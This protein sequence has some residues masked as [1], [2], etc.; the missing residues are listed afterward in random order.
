M[1]RCTEAQGRMI[2]NNFKQDIENIKYKIAKNFSDMDLENNYA[3]EDMKEIIEQMKL[4][5]SRLEERIINK[6]NRLKG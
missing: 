4:E 5:C 1:G 3:H 2:I 6:R